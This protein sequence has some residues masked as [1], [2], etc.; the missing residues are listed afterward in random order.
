MFPKTIS[1]VKTLRYI[2]LYFLRILKCITNREC[3]IKK[4]VD[5]RKVNVSVSVL[6]LSLFVFF[7]KKVKHVEIFL[8][9]INYLSKK[10]RYNQPQNKIAEDYHLNCCSE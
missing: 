10:V 4:G 2:F 1:P 7:R 9:K 8:L 3:E 5:P 6:K